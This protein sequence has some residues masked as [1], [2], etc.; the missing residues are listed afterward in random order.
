MKN[1]PFSELTK[2]TLLISSPEID[3]GP[4]FRTVMLLCE[5]NHTGSFAIAINLPVDIQLPEDI[6]GSEH[7]ENPNIR[8]L[9]GGPVQ[10]NQMMILHSSPEEPSQTVEILPRVYLGG[11]LT[12][13]QKLV[14]KDTDI[15][16]NMCFGYAG[17]A[18][19]QLER[20]Y[21]DGAWFAAEGSFERVF[22]IPIENM[23]KELLRD[24]GG[25]YATYSTMPDDLSL[26]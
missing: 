17:W 3:S 23:W 16:V 1:I 25:K 14:L 8:L 18:A 20:E 10:G 2:G 6:L 15:H 12:F 21:L 7:I 4:F 9:S 5:C 24:L 11:D 22:S 19:G 26:N 13:L